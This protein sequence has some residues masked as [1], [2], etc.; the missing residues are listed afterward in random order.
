MFVNT[1]SL[2]F[3]GPTDLLEKNKIL[4]RNTLE[5]DQKTI[6]R[7]FI[8]DS[9]MLFSDAKFIYSFE[10]KDFVYFLFKETSVEDLV[11]RYKITSRI[12]RVCKRD[13]GTKSSIGRFWNTF[14]KAK[15]SCWFRKATTN[16]TVYYDEIVD[17][18]YLEQESKLFLIMKQ[19]ELDD[20]VVC[21]YDLSEIENKF[22][23]TFN[24]QSSSNSRWLPHEDRQAMKQFQ[25]V[26]PTD[27]DNY[28]DMMNL[29][30]NQRK[31]Q[32]I[33]NSIN[34]N[35]KTLLIQSSLLNYKEIQVDL[36]KQFIKPKRSIYVVYLI[37]S[38]NHLVRFLM[39][40]HDRNVCFVDKTKVL[41]N[42]DEQVLKFKLNRYMRTILI[43]S[44]R[45]FIKVQISNCE[46]YLD[47][48][49]CLAQ[50]RDPYCLWNGLSNKCEHLNGFDN[51]SSFYHVEQPNF[52]SFCAAIQPKNPFEAYVKCSVEEDPGRHCLCRYD[53]SSKSNPFKINS[54]TVDGGWSDWSSWTVCKDGKKTRTRLCNNPLP[55]NGGK[56]CVGKAKEIESCLFLFH[57]TNWTSCSTKCGSGYQTRQQ[58]Y[59][60]DDKLLNTTE[61]RTC[62]GTECTN[63]ECRCVECNEQTNR[64][65]C[66]GDECKFLNS[67]WS[68]CGSSCAIGYQFKQIDKNVFKKRKCDTG[69]KCSANWSE[70]SEWSKCVDGKKTKLRYC[71]G[72]ECAGEFKTAIVCDPKNDSNIVYDDEVVNDCSGDKA[73]SLAYQIK[74]RTSILLCILFFLIGIL[75]GVGIV[76]AYNNRDYF[77]R[78]SPKNLSLRSVSSPLIRADKNT[79]VTNTNRRKGS[80]LNSLDTSSK[81]Q[82]SVS[83][84]NIFSK[85]FRN[86][87]PNFKED[88]F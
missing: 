36:I 18:Y 51:S 83:S 56:Q 33:F 4:V 60:N 44:T 17:A 66:T 23:D 67:I 45:Q 15:I 55:T 40:L 10:T 65:E 87:T 25:C 53:S 82:G 14:I 62:R 74:L 7:S 28:V 68:P 22:N 27:S 35:L 76:F 84:I 71:Y 12:G 32:I 13:L 75:S 61:I 38:D 73:E 58:L 57:T 59:L 72:Q 21:A 64:D 80:E 70:W 54:C 52:S 8:D 77:K 41:T 49:E 50:H 20:S 11:C 48:S 30:Q 69:K 2:Y 1:G 19:D 24:Y 6:V 46:N 78:K 86:G 9:K 16:R 26:L 34:T 3:G 47:R 42:E 81:N 37:T 63:Q 88:G 79:Y 85:K 5:Y 43:G 29:Q 39:N 31:Y